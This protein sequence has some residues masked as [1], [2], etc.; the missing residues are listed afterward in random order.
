MPI[1]NFKIKP[2]FDMT[3]KFVD[4]LRVLKTMLTYA[5]LHEGAKVADQLIEE[6]AGY[7]LIK[8]KDK[9]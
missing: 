2:E 6:V 1:V 7:K 8:I 3:H 9:V 5:K 4:S